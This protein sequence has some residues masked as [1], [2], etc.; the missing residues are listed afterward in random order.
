MWTGKRVRRVS[1]S[2]LEAAQEGR[3]S[4][5]EHAVHLRAN[6]GTFIA[7]LDQVEGYAY[8][9]TAERKFKCSA[10]ATSASGDGARFA[11]LFCAT[12]SVKTLRKI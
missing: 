3:C 5:C 10:S 11:Q 1:V 7:S 9:A 8:D 12:V 6:A 2:L 4:S